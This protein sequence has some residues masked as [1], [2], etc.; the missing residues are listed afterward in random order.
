[1]KGSILSV[2]VV[3]AAVLTAVAVAATPERDFRVKPAGG[4]KVT[5]TGILKSAGIETGLQLSLTGLPRGKKF[6][7]VL[8]TGTCGRRATSILLGIG[9]SGKNGVA[10]YSSLVRRNGAAMAFRSVAD[11]KHVVTIVVS[12]K[13]LACGAIPA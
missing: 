7:V 5:G 6:R 10:H 1:V 3:L 11:G 12:T 13:T 9:T 8:N 2:I 4:S